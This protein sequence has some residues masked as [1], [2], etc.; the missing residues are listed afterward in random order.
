MRVTPR[1]C[2]CAFV[3]FM[4]VY[5]PFMID[6]VLHLKGEKTQ[7]NAADLI[8]AAEVLKHSMEKSLRQVGGEPTAAA[9]WPEQRP[10]AVRDTIVIE[11]AEGRI[12]MAMLHE[13][14]PKHCSILMQLVDRGL[15]DGAI[16][17]RGEPSA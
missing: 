11:V 16:F 7:E 9:P 15:Y 10:A 12:R 13:Y 8:R 5:T 14:A 6:S 1:L 3:C 4:V 2:L 17:Y